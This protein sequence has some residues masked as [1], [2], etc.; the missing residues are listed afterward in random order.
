MIKRLLFSSLLI[1]AVVLASLPVSAQTTPDPLLVMLSIVPDTLD[2]RPT[3][4]LSVSYADYR[5]AE[6]AQGFIKPANSAAMDTEARQRSFLILRRIY[7]GPESL[8]AHL[9]QYFT[10]MPRLV[11]FDWYDI[12]RAL[13]YGMQPRTVMI[14]GGKFD[15]ANI[16]QAL[17]ARQFEKTEV[18]GV[19]VWARFVDAQ[20]N[21]FAQELGDPFGG[22]MGQAARIAIMPGYIANTAYWE[23]TKQIVGAYQQTQKSLADIPDFRSLADA[24]TD[25]KTYSGM[26]IQAQFITADAVKD[27]VTQPA[28]PGITGLDQYAELPTYTLAVLADRQEGDK[29][30][31]LIAVTYPDTDLA[32]RASAELNKRIAGF[33]INNMYSVWNVTVDEPHIYQS[34]A[35]LAVAVVSVS[36]PL[37][38]RASNGMPTPAAGSVFRSWIRAL[39][40]RR[41]HVLLTQVK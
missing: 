9:P 23:M 31:S 30:I 2:V 21:P 40:L 20:M 36:Y 12:D 6:L 1:I 29:Q 28:L 11:G 19:P 38:S 35:G 18:S 34:S 17:S 27:V 13:G 22:D 15:A 10:D 4:G 33:D 32:R 26:L 39:I 41:L 7:A 14:L 37:P 5:A 8:F 24:I 3:D 25:S 16:G